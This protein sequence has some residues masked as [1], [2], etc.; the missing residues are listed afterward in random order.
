[1]RKKVLTSE[2]KPDRPAAEGENNEFELMEKKAAFSTVDKASKLHAENDAGLARIIDRELRSKKWQRPAPPPPSVSRSKTPLPVERPLKVDA[3]SQVET[4][5]IEP[6]ESGRPQKQE[7]TLERR[8]DVE[9]EHKYVQTMDEDIFRPE[10]RAAPDKS[11]LPSDPIS[12]DLDEPA[13][14]PYPDISVT[15]D[16]A[17][18]VD[19]SPF[20]VPPLQSRSSTDWLNIHLKDVSEKDY[21]TDWSEFHAI[22]GKHEEPFIN[23]L[24]I[25]LQPQPKPYTCGEA[26]QEDV[27]DELAVQPTA[28]LPDKDVTQDELAIQATADLPD[29]DIAKDQLAVQPIADLP[30]EDV[31]EAPLIRPESPARM[32]TPDAEDELT[33]CEDPSLQ[34]GPDAISSMVVLQWTPIVIKSDTSAA[35]V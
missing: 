10:E 4:L 32:M 13:K 22:A 1:M 19:W 20:R 16:S 18:L 12:V 25:D 8:E 9:V 17:E 21:H 26:P 27:L 28:D 14:F 23:W 34:L 11:D 24:D 30:S 2:A 5:V 35:L 3:S 6:R 31:P 7:R 29:E 33:G 15:D